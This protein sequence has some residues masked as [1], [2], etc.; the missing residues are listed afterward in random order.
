[1]IY[2]LSKPVRQGLAVGLAIFAVGSLLLVFGW[3]VLSYV[4]DLRE[5]IAEERA[6]VGRL[7]SV[8]DSQSNVEADGNSTSLKDSGLFIDGGSESIRVASLQ[9]QLSAILTAS[10]VKPRSSRAL[11]RRPHNDLHLVGVQLQI[12]APIAQLQKVLLEIERHKPALLVDSLQITPSSMTGLPN[13]DGAGLLDARLD[14][15]AVEL[16]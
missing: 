1:M 7:M 13:D 4:M 2:K 11:P 6:I 8:V 10:G 3:P 16:L 5:N 12:I 15:F 14:V 9:S